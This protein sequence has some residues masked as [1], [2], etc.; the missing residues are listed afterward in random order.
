VTYLGEDG[1]FAE[2]TD[3]GLGASSEDTSHEYTGY[4]DTHIG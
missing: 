1:S 2:A 3:V 4:L